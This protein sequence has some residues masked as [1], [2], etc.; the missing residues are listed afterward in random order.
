MYSPDITAY[1]SGM[2]LEVTNEETNGEPEQLS[3]A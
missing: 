1:S 2:E 3:Q